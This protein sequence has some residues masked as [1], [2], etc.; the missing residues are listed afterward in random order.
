MSMWRARAAAMA[1]KMTAAESPFSWL[2]TATLLRSPQTWSCS[3]A[4]AR[5]VSPAASSTD[6][7]CDWNSLAS[8]P[9][10][11]VLPAP[12]TPASIRMKGCSGVMT[13]GDS[14]GA[15]SP[16]R[17]S[18]SASWSWVASVRPS[19]RTRFCRVSSRYS[20]ASTPT[21]AV[22]RMVSS[23]SN[24]SASILRPAPN[25]PAIWPP[26][27]SRVLASPAFSRWAQLRRGAAGLAS[28]GAGEAGSGAAG[29][30]EDF[31]LKKLNTA[32]RGLLAVVTSAV[33]YHSGRGN[34]RCM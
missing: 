20:V 2:I 6:L 34:Q 10:V 15:S 19:R 30:S 31:D 8:L 14:S 29:G 25:S 33:S 1:S 23:S 4:A 21:S 11:V 5:N 9:M 26:S 22:M 18:F 28:A 12:L 32:R 27:F 13:S 17:A 24:S 7:P 16:T 3:R